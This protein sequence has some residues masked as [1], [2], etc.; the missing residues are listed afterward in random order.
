MP[1][2]KLRA[3]FFAGLWTGLKV[4]WPIMSGLLMVMVALGIAIVVLEGWSMRDGIYF[5]FVSGLTI[6]YGDIV[7]TRPLTRVMAIVIGFTGLLLIALVSAVAVRALNA[8][9]SPRSKQ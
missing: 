3:L 2:G 7:P 9:D 5:A 1:S 4:A 6:G 8:T